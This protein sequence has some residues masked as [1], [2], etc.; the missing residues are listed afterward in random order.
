MSLRRLRQTPLFAF[1][2]HLRALR[3]LA[4][5]FLLHCTHFTFAL[6][7]DRNSCSLCFAAVLV[8]PAISA[9]H[10]TNSSNT[11][12]CSLI[13]KDHWV[14]LRR[15]SSSNSVTV[16]VIFIFK[17]TNRILWCL[18]CKWEVS[19]VSNLNYS[20]LNCVNCSCSTMQ[21]KARQGQGKTKH[22]N[23]LIKPQQQQKQ[24]M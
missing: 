5:P 7:P 6:M 8:R 14:I 18:T 10:P 9:T 3:Q 11:T 13:R 16:T 23:W 1:H 19:G 12:Y 24:N 21:G 15:S 2:L 4:L 17:F 22:M 20:K